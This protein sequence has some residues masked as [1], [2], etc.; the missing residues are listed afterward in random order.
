[1]LNGGGASSTVLSQTSVDKSIDS[2]S[3][4]STVHIVH[5]KNTNRLMRTV[6][7]KTP[8]ARAE[9]M[10]NKIILILIK[11]IFFKYFSAS[12]SFATKFPMASAMLDNSCTEQ[13]MDAEKDNENKTTNE[14][15]HQHTI[16][17][18]PTKRNYFK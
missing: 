6:L 13:L 5:Q 18:S 10:I 4:S 12:S 11:N 2:N 16:N 3:P 9:C 15:H 1:M 8:L 17:D 14:E 7:S